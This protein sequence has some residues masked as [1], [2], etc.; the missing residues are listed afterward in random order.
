VDLVAATSAI[1]ELRDAIGAS[2]WPRALGAAL[3]AWRAYRA[4]ALADLVDALASRCELPARP[5]QVTDV[6]AWWI[7]LA[8][9]YEPVAATALAA[10][11]SE[12][13]RGSPPW[14]ELRTRYPVGHPVLAE[15]VI[16]YGES[17]AENAP[18]H[19]NLVDRLAAI[20]AWPADPRA[21]G[22]L[23]AWLCDGEVPWAFDRAPYG[24]AARVVYE[25]IAVQLRRIGDARI[26]PALAACAAEP[27]GATPPLRATQA[28]LAAQL[29]A[30]LADI[31]PLPAELATQVAALAAA[32]PAHHAA[33]D[34]LAP[35]W[36][37]LAA[38]PGDDAPRLVLADALLERGD[39]RGE[40]FALQCAGRRAGKSRR[41][42]ARLV[43]D[44]WADWTGELA[45]IL[46][47]DG[48]V[49]RRGML[50][51]IAVGATDT[52][53]GSYA[54]LRGRRELACVQIVRPASIT[55]PDYVA[56]LDAFDQLASVDLALP[57]VL[58][59]LRAVRP[60]WA[61]HTVELREASP[62]LHARGA[63]AD[64]VRELLALVPELVELRVEATAWMPTPD[65]EAYRA[66][67]AQLAP[68]VRL[69]T[70]TGR[71]FAHRLEA[72]ELRLAP[73]RITIAG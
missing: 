43:R 57:G 59:A 50:H 56:V 8:G 22:P 34:P 37:E 2:A 25:L 72:A 27:R 44:H 55:A 58:E 46:A 29:A 21:A 49:F 33:A 60:R 51:V 4:P 45:P 65:R 68:H 69:H 40:L 63:A 19:L 11:A 62:P 7:G 32:V 36:A 12:G 70:R 39:A 6:H 64:V 71:G 73:M 1:A 14:P 26:V 47:R 53:A 18:T 54:G 52:P 31:A 16:A 41:R 10:H 61:F 48:C 17:F 20:A 13:V 35:L 24:R 66:E 28:E 15:L 5:A 9:R 67:L 3:A 30:Q 38:Q 23:C 42:E